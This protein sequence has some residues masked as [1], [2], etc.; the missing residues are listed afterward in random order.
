[1][2][3]VGAPEDLYDRPSNRFVA[4]FIGESNFLPAIVRGSKDDVVVADCQ[5]AMIRARLPVASRQPATR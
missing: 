3:Q 4:G 5:G 1:M 2:A